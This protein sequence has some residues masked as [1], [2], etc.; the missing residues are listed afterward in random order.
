MIQINRSALLPYSSRQL[1]DLV[2]DIRSY[3]DYIPGCVDAR[4]LSEWEL[5]VEAELTV[6]AMGV[7]Q[8][9]ATRNTMLDGQEIRME[10]LDGPLKHL[11]GSWVFKALSDSACKI[12]L[13][14]SF[15]TA[16]SLKRL[17]AQQLVERTSTN[18]VDALV[19]RAHES[20]GDRS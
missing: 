7:R 4:F 20:F 5:G 11:V 15:E 9:F 12:E 6:S 17:A 3:P 1:F 10:L 8:S 14:L 18:V 2:A 13:S 19:R 16:G